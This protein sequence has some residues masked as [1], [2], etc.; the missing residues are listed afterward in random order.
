MEP[1]AID[2]CTVWHYTVSGD[3]ACYDIAQNV[4]IPLD[5]FYAWNTEVGDDCI[6]LFLDYYVCVGV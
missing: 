5:A 1:V 4:G 6:I 3:T 2:T